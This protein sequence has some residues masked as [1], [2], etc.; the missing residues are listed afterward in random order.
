MKKLRH[1]NFGDK[2]VHI[3]KS[4]DLSQIPIKNIWSRNF[5]AFAIKT[6]STNFAT[7]KQ[8]KA[9]KNHEIN[10]PTMLYM[11]ISDM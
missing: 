8:I 4:Q 7:D 5:S 9:L 1:L 11:D 2:N 10:N 6:T 3:E